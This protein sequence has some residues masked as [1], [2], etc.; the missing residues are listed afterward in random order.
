MPTKFP[1]GAAAAGAA[2]MTAVLAGAYFFLSSDA[3]ST[4]SA[5]R[6]A[7]AVAEAGA[8]PDTDRRQAVAAS[9]KTGYATCLKDLESYRA[10]AAA[11]LQFT[12]PPELERYVDPRLLA[13]VKGADAYQRLSEHP[14]D[15]ERALLALRDATDV[16]RPPSVD[17]IG[18]PLA[19]PPAD[20]APPQ[21][22]EAQR[23]ERERLMQTLRGSEFDGGLV[24]G[25]KRVEDPQPAPTP[26]AVSQRDAEARARVQRE[27][28]QRVIEQLRR[29][30]VGAAGNDLIA[31]KSGD[32]GGNVD[33]AKRKEELIVKMESFCA[34]ILQ[35]AR[36]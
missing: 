28:T 9:L 25:Q 35:V 16:H 15:L 3:P 17:E 18:P 21:D 27:E 14:K 22:A 1:F 29:T 8:P 10:T 11:Q 33:A 24:K 36:D 12:K 2:A 23:V 34:D 26:D 19:S 30:A 7:P 13:E 20:A 6:E 5:V 32:G 4:A 31:F